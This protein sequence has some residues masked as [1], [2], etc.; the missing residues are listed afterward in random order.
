MI[1]AHKCESQGNFMTTILEPVALRPT[2]IT[3]YTLQD[4]FE[5]FGPMPIQ[6]LRQ[7]PAP[8][9][10]TEDDVMEIHDRENR[11]YELVDGILVEKTVGLYESMAAVRLIIL[12]GTFVRKYRLGEVFGADGFMKLKPGLVRIPDV[13]FVSKTRMKA[14]KIRPGQPLVPLVPELAVEVLSKGNTKKEMDRKLQEFFQAGVQLVW[15]V[16]PR[17]QTVT[18]YHSPEQFE[19]IAPPALLLGDPVLPGL[20][21]SLTELFAPPEED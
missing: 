1:A 11:L 16:D 21:I 9:T 8:G 18:V 19:V 13:S 12:I 3:G 10:A 17:P 14:A 7:E 15:Y 5:R 6:R 20:T 2:E 4:L